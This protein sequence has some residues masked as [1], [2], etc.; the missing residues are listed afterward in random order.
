MAM[1]RAGLLARAGALTASTPI[2]G[3]DGDALVRAVLLPRRE[4]D[5][6]A[7]K[8]L[9]KHFPDAAAPADLPDG[10]PPVAAVAADVG[11]AAA[12]VKS[13]PSQAPVV[14]E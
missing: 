6:D 12:G 2:D 1:V 14:L 7:A 8:S 13:E 11:E 3:L 5:D 10:A 4:G 9:R